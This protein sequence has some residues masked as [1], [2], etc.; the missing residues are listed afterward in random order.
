MQRTDVLSP[1]P[2]IAALQ[3]ALLPHSF[4]ATKPLDLAVTLGGTSHEPE[5]HNAAV[6]LPNSRDEQGSADRDKSANRDTDTNRGF[7]KAI[8]SDGAM[9]R[10]TPQAD[11]GFLWLGGLTSPLPAGRDSV[12]V[13]GRKEMETMRQYGRAAGGWLPSIGVDTQARTRA[14]TH[15]H[16]FARTSQR[17]HKCALTHS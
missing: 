1:L 9:Q 17:L 6:C 4:Q 16:T 13:D 2:V 14:R 7:D 15:T 3:Q 12:C 10:S 8:G 5:S 11:N